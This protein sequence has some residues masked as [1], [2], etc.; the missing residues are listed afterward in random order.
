MRIEW[1]FFFFI[2]LKYLRFGCQC[3][4]QDMC[5]VSSDSSYLGS[6]HS[7]RCRWSWSRSGWST[8]PGLPSGGGGACGSRST[9][10]LAPRQW[11]AAPGFPG[12][13]GQTVGGQNS[14]RIDSWNEQKTL[15]LYV[16]MRTFQLLY[17]N[18][19]E[20]KQPEEQNVGP[21]SH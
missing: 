2:K 1:F 18:T 14:E 16:S 11:W 4:D 12:T 10:P 3:S 8:C 21:V 17:T 7:P 20:Q 15:L 9:L 19:S 13:P 6:R 5:V